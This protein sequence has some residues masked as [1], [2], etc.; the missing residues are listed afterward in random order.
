[1][2]RFILTF[3]YAFVSGFLFSFILVDPSYKNMRESGYTFLLSLYCIFW[4]VCFIIYL[5]FKDRIKD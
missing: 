4:P 5:I 3:T 1:M 2:L